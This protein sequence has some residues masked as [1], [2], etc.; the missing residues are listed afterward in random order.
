[1]YGKNFQDFLLQQALFP[2]PTD[3]AAIV[4][5]V[6]QTVWRPRDTGICRVAASPAEKGPTLKANESNF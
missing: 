5:P 4:S 6:Q 2:S 3:T 1:M